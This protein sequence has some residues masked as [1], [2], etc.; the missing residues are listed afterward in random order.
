MS[1]TPDSNRITIAAKFFFEGDHKF[2]IQGVTYGPFRPGADNVHLTSPEQARKDFTQIAAAG[3]NLL[4]L[5]HSPP[6]WFV[7]LAWEFRLRIITTIPWPLRGLFLNNQ[8]T[9]RQIRENARIAAAAHA[10]HPAIFGF[11]VDNEMQPDLVRWYG[12]SRVESFLDSLVTIVK[13]ED[14]GA[15]TSYANFP[16]TEYLTPRCV[17][18]YSYNVYLED[19]HTFR[20][21]LS[22][23]QNIVG[24]KPLVFGEFGLDTIR[25]GEQKQANLLSAH[26]QEVFQGGAAG[27]MIF[28]FTDDW[29]TGGHQITNWSFGIVDSERKPKL[30]Y[31]VLAQKTIGPEG[32]V[33]DTFPLETMPRV[34]V[35][36]CSY[37]GA[38]TLRGCLEAL[39]KLKYP[40]YEVIL[41]DDGSKDDTQNIVKDFPNVINIK[42]PNMGLSV[43]RNIGAQASTGSIIAYT[44]SDCM[45]DS[46]WLY[47]LIQP[48]VTGSYAAVGGPNISPPATDWIQAAVAAAPG[49]PSHVLLSD[50]EAEHVPGCNMAFH[51]WALDMIGGFDPIYRKAGDDVDVCWRLMQLNQK[52]GFSP[53][54]VV[55]HHRRFTV[56][57][58]FNQQKGY[59][60]AESMLRYKHLN[61][62]DDSGSARWKGTIY[63]APL[64]DSVIN[65]SVIY[66]G[67]FGMG[68]FQSI[69][70][71][72]EP[73]WTAIVGSLQWNG[74]ALFILLL[75]TQFEFLRVVPLVMFAITLFAAWSYM[76][77][78][79]IEPQYD[80]LR[81]R[82][83]LLYLALAQPVA[84]AW[85]RYFTWI[86]GKRTPDAVA[87]SREEEEHE[88]TT[89]LGSGKLSFWGEKGK[90]RELLLQQIIDLLNK[91]GWRYE[92]DNGW[93]DWDLEIFGSRWWHV[94]IRTLSEHYPEEKRLT[95]VLNLLRPNA[96]SVL[97]SVMGTG[98]MITL[99]LAFHLPWWL[100]LSSIMTGLSYWTYRGLA[101]RLRLADLIEAAAHATQM[102]QMDGKKAW[103]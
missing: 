82:L 88:E 78:A 87:S 6:R 9:K 50:V 94:R 74:L 65:E 72:P 95:C 83:L 93:S 39:G 48:L 17:D 29:F 67:V 96:S 15:L 57:A 92:L 77:R 53:S 3:F 14:P 4:R 49:S 99:G 33:C 68:F 20:S 61:Y 22:R 21:Y 2:F 16:P 7:D 28:S 8:E 54:A 1:F 34:S 23:L 43:A 60:E 5:Y 71:R 86:S 63:G 52:I 36:V 24:E 31:E 11:Y 58:Y 37:N 13:K 19:T 89:L 44:D 59:G 12:A 18:F 79:R 25:N 73:M 84:R 70:R 32:R 102:T 103:K 45:P 10:G 97:A 41:V 55:W 98:A 30:A 76:L 26:Y 40:D 90:G 27:T 42:Q 35:V 81:A 80:T 47:Y 66:R 46:D 64:L 38:K 69:Y 100:T 91:E 56:G 101:L 62:F 85:A 51:R 75:S